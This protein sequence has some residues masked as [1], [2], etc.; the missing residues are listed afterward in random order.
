MDLE[1]EDQAWE[2]ERQDLVDRAAVEF[3]SALRRA[4]FKR[5]VDYENLST[6]H[7]VQAIYVGPIESSIT[8]WSLVFMA[9]S[10]APEGFANVGLDAFDDPSG[11]HVHWLVLAKYDGT[12]LEIIDPSEFCWCLDCLHD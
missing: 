1:I 5:G 3:A 9:L 6:S 7:C 12:L 2:R 11:R 8:A 4:G 10:H